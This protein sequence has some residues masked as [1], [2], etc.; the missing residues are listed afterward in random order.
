MNGISRYIF[1]IRKYEWIGQNGVVGYKTGYYQI[2]LKVAKII[3]HIGTHFNTMWYTVS[4]NS[5]QNGVML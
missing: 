3:S 1:Y 2:D 5:M 4:G